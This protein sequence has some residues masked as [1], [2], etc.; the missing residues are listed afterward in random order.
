MAQS[1][2][3]T[4]PVPSMV[5]GASDPVCRALEAVRALAPM[6]AA[7]RNGFDGGRRL[8]NEVFEALA[9]AGLFRLWLPE[10]LGGPELSPVEFMRVVE[11]ASALDGSVGWLV[12]NGGGMSRIGGY[13]GEA[14]ARD[15][16][17]DRRI[18]VASSTGA[19]GTATPV[20]GGYCVSGRWPFGSGAHHAMRFMVLASP[21]P[22]DPDSPLICCYL[23]QSDVTILDNWHVSGLR[24]TGSCDF[25]ARDIFVPAAHA[26][27]FLGLQPTQPGLLYRMPPSSVFA[28][29]ICGVPLGIASGAIASFAELA[30]QKSRLGT[31][32]LL[33]DREIVQA[34]V[35]RTRA[36]LRAARAFLMDTMSELIAATDT[37]G[38]R[39]V[40]ARANVRIANAHAAEAAMTVTD[41]LAAS[42][43]AAAIFE[44]CA[45]ERA[46]RDV[47][48][49][50]KH[51]AMSPNNY[52]I[53]GRLALGLNPG[54]ARF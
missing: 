53:A 8:P 31:R 19:V 29:S 20:D 54:T 13:L 2:L 26:H 52:I 14:V 33:R 46:A 12:G 15:W 4:H 1:D 40:D 24:G 38:E 11:A 43:G 36:M 49:A 6:I 23:S 39:L 9:D 25:E 41:M 42:A 35:G 51:I 16:F 44:T 45:L 10:A 7:Q 37:G 27:P 30:C 32:A 48:A 17:A 50:A 18:F 22:E 21:K 28:W 34:T 3:I 5:A 47:R